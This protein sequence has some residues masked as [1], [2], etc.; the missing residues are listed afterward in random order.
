MNII[1]S[2]KPKWAEL[3]YSGQKTIEW[4]KSF[5][6]AENIDKVLLYETAPVKAITG[7]FT[8]QEIPFYLVSS[9][10]AQPEQI[11]KN[12]CVPMVD[13]IKYRANV[14]CIYGW[15]I[16]KVTKFEEPLPLSYVDLKRPPQSWCY[17]C[18]NASTG[19]DPIPNI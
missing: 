12:G 8:L 16:D 6:K 13:L 4:R 7:F 18:L 11:I 5:P 14:D 2:I 3:I 10:C 15:M 19:L 1:L 9:V 17:D